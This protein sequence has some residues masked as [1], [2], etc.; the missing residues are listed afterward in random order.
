[1]IKSFKLK[2]NPTKEQK[3]TFHKCFGLKRFIYNYCITRQIE[4]YNK[5]LARSEFKTYD[6]CIKLK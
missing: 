5:G 1:M 3:I 2:L 6:S 4:N